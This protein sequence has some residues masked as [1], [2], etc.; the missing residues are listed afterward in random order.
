MNLEVVIKEN[1]TAAL[2][3]DIGSGDITARLLPNKT[4]TA[5]I[6]CRE[7]AMLC[8]KDWVNT[9]FK[10]VNPDVDVH[11]HFTDGDSLTPNS[12]V[13]E[14]SG[15]VQSILTAERTA[16]NFLQ[17]LSGTATTTN[18]YVKVIEGTGCTLLDTRKTLPG[19]RVA[20]K[21]AV[22]VGGGQNH[23]MG[24][25]DAFLIKEN[26]I[27]AAGSITEA[28]NKARTL[29]PNC[30]AEVEVETLDEYQEAL[31]AQPDRI[32]LDNFTL[33]MI[34]QAVALPHDGVQLEVSGG[35]DKST[36]TEYAQTGV[37]FI[38]LGA[39]TKHLQAIDF[40]LLIVE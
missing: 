15:P 28:V 4:A 9:T 7:T 20:Q 34:H 22:R 33:E 12:I 32:M 11:W 40:S 26:H 35:V 8:G 23:R 13:A 6:I 2:K 16:L 18:E 21:Y 38:S 37:D 31:S 5:K 24:L 19:L 36:L 30:L 39:L 25:F 10:M 14:I 27:K 17:T 29:N 3:E 1:V